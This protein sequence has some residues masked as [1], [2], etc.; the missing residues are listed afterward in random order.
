MKQLSML[1]AALLLLNVLS[2]NAQSITLTPNTNGNPQEGRLYYDNSAKELRFWNGSV[3]VPVGNSGSPTPGWV[4]S[5]AN[6]YNANTGNLGVGTESPTSKL[7]IRHN[8]S[9]ILSLQN[10]NALSTG[11]TNSI[12]FG[13][14]NYTTG[15]IS[16][17]GTSSSAARMAFSTG[18]SFSGGVFSMQERLSIANDGKVGV[19]QPSPQATLDVGGSIRFSGSNPAAFVVTATSGVNTYSSLPFSGS[20]TLITAAGGKCYA[21]RIDHPMCNNNANAILMVTAQVSTFGGVQYNNGYWYLIPSSNERYTVGRFS[22]RLGCSDTAACVDALFI[23]DRESEY[24]FNG[25][26]FNVLI[27][28]N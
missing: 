13:G 24:F 18:Y 4:N 23:G 8:F 10:L 15:I 3:Y 11:L 28:Q 9:N 1:T 21:I 27:I 19:N 2:L 26:K 6:L 16:T 17:I 7:T 14:S 25:N 22:A 5:G 20:P 12:L